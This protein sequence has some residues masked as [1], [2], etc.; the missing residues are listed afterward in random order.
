MKGAIF[1]NNRISKY[2]M[3]AIVFLLS[4][5]VYAQKYTLNDVLNKIEQNNPSILAYQNRID[6]AIEN[7]KSARAWAPPKAGV[8]WDML[9][10][11]LDYDRGS[12][13]RLSAMQD[14]PNAKRNSAKESYMKSIAFSEKYAGEFHKVELFAEAK[15]VYYKIY[16]SQRRIAVLRESG[17]ALS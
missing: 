3:L 4:V 17:D 13:L 8:E 15:E 6:A 12:M 9:P 5:P 7:A 16:I 2:G 11:N 10:Y 1:C 14:F